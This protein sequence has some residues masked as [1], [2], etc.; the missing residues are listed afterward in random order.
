MDPTTL[1]AVLEQI[2]PELPT[3]AGDAW[4]ELEPKLIDYRRQLSGDDKNA[5]IIQVH[6]LQ[7]L[8]VYPIIYRRLLDLT[9]QYNTS[10]TKGVVRSVQTLEGA[11]G[12]EPLEMRTGT[13]HT[14]MRYTDIACPRRVWVETPRIS[15]VVRLTVDQPEHSVVT[16]T[17]DELS[18]APV[19]IQL[20]APGFDL[21]NAAKQETPILPDRDSPPI[22]FDLKPLH[23]GHQQLQLDFCQNGQPLRT[24]TVQIQVTA[25]EV[26]EDE[27]VHTHQS[28]I[29]QGNVAPPDLVLHI[30]CNNDRHTLEFTLI[31]DG[32]SWWRSFHP[33]TLDGSPADH[34]VQLYRRITSLADTEDSTMKTLLKRQLVIPAADVDRQIRQLGYHLWRTLLPAELRELYAIEREQWH[35]HSLLIYSDEP[36]LP[37]ELIWPHD[38]AKGT[39]KDEAPWCVTTRLTRWL[40]R[41]AQ[42]NGNEAA[43]GKLSLH[44]AAVLAPQYQLLNNLPLA[45]VERDTLK[46]LFATHRVKD[47]SPTAASWSAMMDLLESGT[48]DWIH[49]ASHGSFYA[50][51]PT[52]DSAIWLDQD[53]ALTP[54]HIGGPEMALHFRQKRPAFV[55]NACE[56]GRQGWALTRIGGWA[57]QLI[58]MNAGLFIGPLWIVSDSGAA[59]FSHTFY[60]ALLKGETVGSAVQE[61]RLAARTIGDP[62]WLAYSVYAHPNARL[63]LG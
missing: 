51:A 44:A 56:V 16:E 21:L 27:A 39:W 32:G 43:P 34:A 17:L 60:N 22:V 7:A 20:V 54:E 12:Q 42:G 59:T 47:I 5:A 50:Q 41:D 57:N 52:S 33:V 48:Y 36:H 28:V 13:T 8:I 63:A 53:K 6:I 14:I 4:E 10:G 37:W 9:A 61:A 1:Q 18:D 35:N 49:L 62:T 24:I 40:R 26:A 19:Q 55:F 29:T 3:L 30:S 25:H 58:S 31:R 2:W 11:I 23:T 46:A 45:P 38:D 15:V